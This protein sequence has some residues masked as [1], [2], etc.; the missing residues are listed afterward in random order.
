MSASPLP[1][2]RLVGDRS[3][4]PLGVGCWPIGG[5]A[6]NLGMPI[7]W[8][9]ATDAASLKGLLTAHEMGATVFDTA[10]VYGL[11]H[12]QRLLGQ[13]LQHVPRESLC[14]T[15]KIGYFRGTAPNA[16]SPSQLLHQV[17]QSLENLDTDYL[18]VLSLH[19]TDFGPRDQYLDDALETLRALREVGTI[20]AIGMRGPHRLSTDRL[21]QAPRDREDKRD[22]FAYLFHRVQPDVIS[23]RYNP[24]TPE[25]LIGENDEDIFAF[26]RRHGA[27]VTISKPLVQGLLTGKYD[28]AAPPVFGPG[29]HRLRKRWFTPP[30]LD[31]IQHGLKPL[32][33]HFGPTSR[34]LTRVALRYCLQRCEHAIVLVGFTTPQHITDNYTCLGEPLTPSEQALARQ[35]YTAL[36]SELDALGATFLDEAHA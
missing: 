36:R 16:Y 28:P 32:Q 25:T 24:L 15:S 13:M 11:G 30:A 6:D 8:S 7:G 21:T 20:R 14:I 17:R 22:R 4:H 9:T 1:A 27:A 3:E 2:R 19:N 23:T 31:V 12:S 29:D 26:A 18:D 33:E 5:P 10:D 35:T 34:D